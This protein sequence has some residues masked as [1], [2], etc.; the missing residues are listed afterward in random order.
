[1]YSVAKDM[2]KEGYDV[3]LVTSDKDMGQVLDEH[4]FIYDT[5]KEELLDPV[6]FAE[7]N[8]FPVAKLPFYFALLGDTSDNIPGVRGI[9]KKGALELVHQFDTLEE[10]YAHLDKIASARTALETYKDNAFLSR[11][12][13]LLRYYTCDI[14]AKDV[15]F[16]PTLRYR[17]R[18]LFVKLNFKSL[19]K[20][21]GPAADPLPMHEGGRQISLFD[22]PASDSTD[23]LKKKESKFHFKKVTS[24]ADL[25]ELVT[26]LK[27]KKIF[28]IDTETTGIKPISDPMVGLSFATEEGKAWYVPFGHKVPEEQLGQ[29]EIFEV[30]RPILEDPGYKK[31]MHN[32]SFDVAVLRH[33]GILL[34]GVLFD[35]MLAARLINLPGQSAGLKELSERFLGE[36]MLTYGEVVSN[37]GYRNFSYVPLNEATEYA[38]ADAHQTLLLYPVLQK[39]LEKEG[40]AT[41]FAEIEQPLQNILLAMEQEGIY[42]DRDELASLGKKILCELIELED[43]I[44]QSTGPQFAGINLNS[45]KQVQN[46]LFQELK[47]PTQKKSAKGSFSTDS[48]VLKELAKLHPVPGMIAKYRELAKLKNTYIDALPT[49]VDPVTGRIHTSFN[50]SSVATGRLSSSEPNLQNIPTG[51]DD[52]GSEIRAA[53]K[54]RPDELFISADYSQIELRVMAYLSQD[55][56]LKKAFI[57]SEDIHR[58]TAARLFGVEPEAVTHQQRQIGKRINFSVLYGMTPYGLSQDLGIPLNEAK[59]Y[60]ETYFEQYPEVKVWME[61]TVEQAKELGYVSTLYGRRRYVR[62]LYEANK[63]LYQE[64]VRV[65][66][67]TPVQGTAADLMKIGMVKLAASYARENI[68]AQIVLQI[69]DELLISVKKG[70][71]AQAEETARNVLSGIVDWDIPL[72]VTT[73]IGTDWKEVTK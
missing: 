72:E 51:T 50:Q 29:T 5:F 69:H 48:A 68:P 45:P 27:E 24:A 35:T 37:R 25:H 14:T 56:V 32:A 30:L 58:Q 34:R 22:N 46:L 44:I 15:H 43:T 71:E 4:T 7:K 36:S 19:L 17:A 13:F 11:E 26:A 10:L 53:F 64:A 21:L 38:A 52:Y 40:L 70:F 23:A 61:R 1:M 57:Q 63:A 33:A 60:I 49:Y 39:L 18:P 20:D 66:V 12:L 2:H 59:K 3:V 54:P 67:N 31:I 28:G 55:P 41:L 16:N 42:L 9:G 6:A 8:N 62:G 47:L 65:T 73:R